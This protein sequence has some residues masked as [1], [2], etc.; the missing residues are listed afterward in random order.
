MLK[1]IRQIQFIINIDK[2][3][4]LFSCS[5]VMKR[6]L[7]CVCAYKTNINIHQ[8]DDSKLTKNIKVFTVY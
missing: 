7:A 8:Y 2:W 3:I 5:S 4:T 6:K 1:I